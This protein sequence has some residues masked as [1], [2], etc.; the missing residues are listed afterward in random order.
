MNE[1]FESEWGHD[2]ELGPYDNP[3]DAFLEH[4]RASYAEFL[5]M[6]DCQVLEY[7]EH[8]RWLHM[9]ISV[10][11]HPPNAEIAFHRDSHNTP[12]D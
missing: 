10:E 5:G 1:N 2:L 3:H 6:R 8:R 11:I 9:P 12:F 7:V 4:G